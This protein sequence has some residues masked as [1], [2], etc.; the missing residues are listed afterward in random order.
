MTYSDRPLL[1]LDVDGVLNP[2]GMSR[3]ALDKS[4][5]RKRD[6][7]VA[8]GRTFP[9][10]LNREH[11]AWLLELA[12]ACDLELVWATTWEDEANTLIAPRLGLPELPVV[13]FNFKAAKF[14]ASPDWKCQAVLDY[15]GTRPLAWLDDDF[16]M[17]ARERDWFVEKRGDIPTLLRTIPARVGLTNVDLDAVANWA[18]GGASVPQPISVREPKTDLHRLLAM[19]WSTEPAPTDPLWLARQQADFTEGFHACANGLCDRRV[20]DGVGYCCTPCAV[21]QQ[22]CYEIHEDGPLGHTTS[23]AQRHVERSTV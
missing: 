11:G 10:W 13:H 22:K 15:A 6:T 12:Q 2:F 4:N 1:L 17:F 18:R 14:S 19:P 16:E 3:N 7:Q 9:V 23:C 21:A 8:D 5:Y 20:K